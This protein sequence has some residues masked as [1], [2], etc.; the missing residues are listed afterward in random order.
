MFGGA[1]N[2]SNDSRRRANEIFEF[3]LTG[4]SKQ[5]VKL[6]IEQTHTQTN[7]LLTCMEHTKKP[8][9]TITYSQQPAHT[10]VHR[11]WSGLYSVCGCNFSN[12]QIEIHM[13]KIYLSMCDRI[14]LGD[15]KTIFGTHLHYWQY[16][17][18][19]Q[20]LLC[21]VFFW[22]GFWPVASIIYTMA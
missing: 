11:L 12:E 9:T 13:N 17:P 6:K 4:R 7:L 22:L 8:A 14:W 18:L 15:V 21:S 2:G 10:D 20:K 5:L 3:R 16:I 1:S 19:F